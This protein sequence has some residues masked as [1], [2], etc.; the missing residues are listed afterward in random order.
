MQH[1]GLQRQ[2]FAFPVSPSTVSARPGLR[3]TLVGVTAFGFALAL[4]VAASPIVSASYRA[5]SSEASRRPA[6]R[7]FIDEMANKHGFDRTELESAFRKT[8]LD[9]GIVKLMN[10]QTKPKPWNEYRAI[11]INEEKLASG[12]RF[13]RQHE[14][15]LV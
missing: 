8:K 2:F 3:G 9:P 6:V 11:F 7:A 4:A 10:R 1:K 13:W 5:T 14:R 12:E 15:H